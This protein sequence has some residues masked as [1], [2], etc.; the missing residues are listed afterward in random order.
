MKVCAVDVDLTVVDSASY[1][2]DWLEYRTKAGLAKEE[3]YRNYDLSIPYT[4][5][6]LANGLQGSPMDFWRGE[7]TYDDMTPLEG[8]VEALKTI[9]DAGYDI[10]FVSAL[11]GHH[12]RSKYNFLEKH[13]PFMDGFLGTQEKKYVKADIIIDD[14]NRFLNMF[15]GGDVLRL[16]KTTI[17]SQDEE[18][19][20]GCLHFT[21]WSILH[22]YI[23]QIMEAYNK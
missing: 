20:G 8:S 2:Y 19:R 23:P 1:W 11:K 7:H 21:D 13:F 5:I 18:L 14:R 4:S 12:H 3:V 6:W 16:K 9:K 15:N 10:V 22:E 17:H